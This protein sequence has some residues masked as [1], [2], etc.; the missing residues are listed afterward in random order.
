MKITDLRCVHIPSI[1]A[2]ILRI[3]TDEGIY[4]LSQVEANKHGYQVGQILHYRQFILGLDPTDVEDVMRRIRRLGG[5]KPW[6]AAVSSI[7][8]ALW[9]IAG[10]SAGLPVY[11]LLGGKVRDFVRV[12]IG[13]LPPFQA[14]PACH[15]PGIR[16]EDFF[17]RARA[18]QKIAQSTGIGIVKM[19]LSF[20]NSVQCQF[21]GYDY[22]I[23]YPA[24]EHA[25][26][27]VPPTGIGP[28]SFAQSS[29]MITE[30]GMAHTVDCIV[31]IREGLGDDIAMALDCGPG[32]KIPGA[33]ELARRIEHLRPF[34][35]EDLITGDYMPY[36]IPADY[37]EIR[38]HTSIPIHTGEQIYL[39]Q[40]CREL[41]ETHAV[42][43]I[44]PDPMDVGGL[45]EL[46]WVAE[47]A[48]LHGILIAPHGIGD[49]PF[50]LAAHLQ[51]CAT[52]PDNYLA[53]E[54]PMVTPNWQGLITGFEDLTIENGAIRVPDRPGLGIDLVEE[55]IQ[56]ILG[57][58]DIYVAQA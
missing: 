34:W 27:T 39:R 51:V 5:F 17:N 33:V 11:K 52:L 55:E 56:R 3:D 26:Q 24:N 53:F 45:A 10:K 9:D 44:G 48:D 49:G 54:L 47:Y 38:K 42:D 37:R 18:R 41:I 32:W 46:K 35:L 19:G 40:N 23:N 57:N 8:I 12:Y 6:G 1:R 14:E 29:G 4:G 21:P 7:E 13:G 30:R 36:V 20:H 58:K 15:A 28:N 22:G 25:S 43:V 16:P 50:G 2:L 31:A